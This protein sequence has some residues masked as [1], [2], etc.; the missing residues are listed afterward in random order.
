MTD[1]ANFKSKHHKSTTTNYYMDNEKIKSRFD[2]KYRWKFLDSWELEIFQL[3]GS[4]CAFCGSIF[5]GYLLNKH[6][7]VSATV[8]S[9]A[10]HKLSGAHGSPVELTSL[11]TTTKVLCQGLTL[12]II[13]TVITLIGITIYLYRL[14]KTFTLC[15]GIKYSNMATLYLFASIDDRFLPLKLATIRGHITMFTCKGE[16]TTEHVKLNTSTFWDTIQ[17]T[18]NE[19]EL[20]YNGKSINIPADITLSIFDK[21]RARHIINSP[22]PEYSF[23]V[24]QGNTWYNLEDKTFQRNPGVPDMDD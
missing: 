19:V 6:S 5:S 3:L 7:K 16:L 1:N 22:N 4:I 13:I 18:W 12:S 24:K 8:A 10:L 2:P 14:F 15:K 11:P 21:M 20:Q 23:L 9:M 17:I